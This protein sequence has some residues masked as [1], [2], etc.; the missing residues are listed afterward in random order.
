MVEGVHRASALLLQI[1]SD[2]VLV[3]DFDTGSFILSLRE[4]GY[5]L[6]YFE[7]GSPG[8]RLVHLA[9]SSC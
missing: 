7:T 1:L 2:L 6:D 8:L 9:G 3:R 4:E 5:T